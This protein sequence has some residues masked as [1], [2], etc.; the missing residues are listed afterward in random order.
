MKTNEELIT[1]CIAM[2]QSE[3]QTIKILFVILAILAMLLYVAFVYILILKQDN[4]AL[5]DNLEDIQDL[6]AG[7]EVKIKTNVKD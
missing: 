5:K 3:M 6:M 4:K 1:D 2:C 7:T